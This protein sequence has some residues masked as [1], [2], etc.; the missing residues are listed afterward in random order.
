MSLE[1][2]LNVEKIISSISSRFVGKIDLNDAIN[3]S[4]Q[5]LGNLSEADR[6]SLFLFNGNKD[7]I[8]NTHE[9]CNKGIKS[10][11]EIL[12]KIDKN[13]ISW[14]TRQVEKLNFV[15]IKEVSKLPAEAKLTK[16]FMELQGIKSFLGFP[17]YHEIKVTGFVC[18]SKVVEEFPWKGKDFAILR[19]FSQI[20]ES[21]FERLQAEN[22]LRENQEFLSAMF[23]AIAEG[24]IAINNDEHITRLNERF[25]YMWRVEDE[26]IEKMDFELLLDN[27]S[28]QLKNPKHFKQKIMDLKEDPKND[29]DMIFFKD[30]RIFEQYSCPITLEGKIAG[31]LWSFRDVSEHQHAE[32]ELRKS[33]KRY[34][35]AYERANF[36]KDIFTHDMNNIFH[37]I[38]FSAELISMFKDKPEELNKSQ[39]IFTTIENQ[40]DRGT[41]LI[42]NV[43]KLSKLEDSNVNLKKV[44]VNDV[45]D[46]AITFATKSIREKKLDINIKK[47]K[48]TIYVEANDLLLDVFENILHN[49]IKYN[50]NPEVKIQVIFT[51]ESKFQQKNLRIEFIDNGI[52]IPDESKELIFEKGYKKDTKIRGMGIGL[53]LVKKI[54]ESF[55]GEIWVQNRVKDDYQQGSNFVVLIPILD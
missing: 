14:W 34:R 35:N 31:R 3:T 29:F 9:W 41:K 4:L 45:L 1:K 20:L 38:Q 47:V 49:S 7:C 51:I 37:N 33:E 54:V 50:K 52:G 48:E 21:T 46:E 27:I 23:E 53:S 18:F 26:I 42:D 16:E 2:R 28:D 43:R 8:T 22:A 32:Q 36:Y 39:D 24:I 10:Q 11:L 55:K 5:D 44:M 13:T 17:I 12:Q 19:I 40:I 25:I 15:N 30:G 6:V